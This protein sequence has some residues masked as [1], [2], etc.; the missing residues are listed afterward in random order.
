MIIK[1][2][3]GD[4]IE[5]AKIYGYPM[6]HG[7]NCFHTMGAGLALQVKKQFPNAYKADKCTTAHGDLCKLGSYSASRTNTW[8]YDVKIINAYTQ[9]APGPNVDY[10]A[11]FNAF[12][13]INDEKPFGSS[14]FLIPK[15]GA[16][17][18]GGDW[19]LIEKLINLATPDI[20]I[21][22]VE[23]RA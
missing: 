3:Y 13:K 16:G 10:G 20:E 17:I 8:F 5:L 21:I 6:I 12:K 1:T 23:Y 2:E 11:V 9:Y 22:L 7:C 18:A 15:I 14:K 19:D 4:I